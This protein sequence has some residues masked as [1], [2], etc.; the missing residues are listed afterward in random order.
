MISRLTIKGPGDE[1]DAEIAAF[2]L[3]EVLEEL[4]D[5]APELMDL[6]SR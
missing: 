3:D 2:T 6:L 5:T 1:E 4:R